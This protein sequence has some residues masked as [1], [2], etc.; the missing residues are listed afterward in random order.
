[1]RNKIIAVNA[2]IVLIVGVLS[3]VLVRSALS[4][5]ADNPAQ[6]TEEAKH[7]VQ[8]AS[9]RLQFDAL[10]TER[11]LA[12]KATEPATT[13]ALSKATP[14]A[15]GDAA[16]SVCDNI[17]SVSKGVLDVPPSIV[18]IVDAAGRSVARNGSTLMRGDDLG[19]VYP[20]LKEAIAT[21]RS[22]S[23]LWV[24]KARND[25]YLVSYAPVRDSGGTVLGA[26]VA[27]TTLNDELSR[28]SDATTGRALMIVVPAGGDL[29]VVSHSTVSNSGLESAINGGA[30]DM[31]K[32]VLSSGHAS[33]TA[34][35]D[36]FV[37]ASGLE[38][39]GGSKR[40]EA[41][42]VAALPA[43]L[44][45]DASSL[46]NPILLA[47]VLGLVAVVAGGWLLGNY[48]TRPIQTLE[49]G[50]LQI[51]NGQSDKRFEL[52]HPDLGG[53]AFRIDQLLNQL[54][55]VEEDTTDEEG[56]VSVA[57]TAKNFSEAMSVDDRAVSSGGVDPNVVRHLAAEPP[58]QYY[59]RIYREYVAAKKAL[60]EA[61][62]HIT[63]QAFATRIQGMEKDKAAELGKPVRYQV[64]VSGKEVKLL[65]IPV[66]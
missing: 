18:V 63:E 24:N 6:L 57:P 40:S 48:I 58:A 62:D 60:G 59:A 7:D 37:A 44:I 33:A 5:A 47:M 1:M 65:V 36:Q 16:M 30:K 21:G 39:L 49:E 15:R 28:V 41:V 9:A 61:T 19:S 4:S 10:R 66:G 14:A 55:G 2:V 25:Q 3:W 50:L 17:A 12:A 27:G 29:Q 56:R 35:G 26:V 52:D 31:I 32:N 20:A 11:W 53:L 22:G 38:G 51:L 8:G 42:V 43:S 13:D 34:A 64:Q 46:A 54:M 23:D 45:A